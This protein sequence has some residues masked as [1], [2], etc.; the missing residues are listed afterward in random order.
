MRDILNQ[1]IEIEE[2]L[3]EM[4]KI[5]DQKFSLMNTLANRDELNAI[6]ELEAEIYKKRVM[7]QKKLKRLINAACENRGVEHSLEALLTHEKSTE[8]VHV[9]EIQFNILEKQRDLKRNLQTNAL[10][11]RELMEGARTVLDNVAATM[12]KKDNSWGRKY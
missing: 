7:S 6:H 4:L 10:L 2:Y 1:L 8:N 5:S 9:R 11:A 3:D 12:K